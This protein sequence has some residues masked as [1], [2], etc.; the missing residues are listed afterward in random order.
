MPGLDRLVVETRRAEVVHWLVPAP[1]VVMPAWNPAWVIGVMAAYAVAANAPCVIVQRYNR[2][3]L[4]S[5]LAR[6][7]TNAWSA[8]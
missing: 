1:I 6:S 4:Q 2:A 7:A 3:R 5:V 8:P